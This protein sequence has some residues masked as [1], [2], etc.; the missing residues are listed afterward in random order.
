MDSQRNFCCI[1]E[2]LHGLVVNV[3]WQQQVFARTIIELFVTV[4]SLCMDYYETI[5]GIIEF[6]HGRLGGCEHLKVLAWTIRE[7]LAT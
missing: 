6:L 1:N 7:Y 4:T 2:L 5:H 3:L